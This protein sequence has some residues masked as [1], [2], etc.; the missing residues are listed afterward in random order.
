VTTVKTPI[1]YESL[2]IIYTTKIDNKNFSELIKNHI[3]Q[4]T[5]S[6]AKTLIFVPYIHLYIATGILD[7]LNKDQK[8]LLLF[9]GTNICEKAIDLLNKE[10]TRSSSILKP[11]T[12][13]TYIDINSNIGKYEKSN[14]KLDVNSKTNQT[15]LFEIY[16]TIIIGVS[17]SRQASLFFSEGSEAQGPNI[18]T[19]SSADKPYPSASVMQSTGRFRTGRP[20]VKMLFKANKTYNDEGNEIKYSLL[21]TLSYI[22]RRIDVNLDKYIDE[23]TTIQISDETRKNTGIYKSSKTIEIDIIK[24]CICKNTYH[25]LDAGKTIK[26]ITDG[27]L[28]NSLIEGLTKQQVIKLVKECAAGRTPKKFTRER[29]GI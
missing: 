13:M 9:R 24:E 7:G 22:N 6:S 15:G 29:L 28:N 10:F 12:N 8:T 14:L 18:I 21:D 16:D 25:M 26:Q 2:N 4:A 17:H 23:N 27:F 1:K 19:I 20:N 5:E 3:K 11:D